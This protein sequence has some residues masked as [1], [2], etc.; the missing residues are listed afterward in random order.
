MRPTTAYCLDLLMRRRL[1]RALLKTACV[2]LVVAAIAAGWSRRVA[3]AEPSRVEITAPFPGDILR[4]G[5]I[6][7][8]PRNAVVPVRSQQH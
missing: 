6:M 1:R 8:S 2:L 5:Q 7:A 3:A 4:G